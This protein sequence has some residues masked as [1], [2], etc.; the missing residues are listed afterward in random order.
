MSAGGPIRCRRKGICA[1]ERPK[2]GRDRDEIRRERIVWPGGEVLTGE[3]LI[4]DAFP[5]LGVPICEEGF[6]ELA[7]DG[8]V[9]GS[10]NR[11]HR[12]PSL[13]RKGDAAPRNG[14]V[15]T[16]GGPIQT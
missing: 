13:E 2:C 4:D 9:G 12:F 8:I 15:S 14:L 3:H 16:R 6:P 1:A 10:W 7:A 5:R 11:P